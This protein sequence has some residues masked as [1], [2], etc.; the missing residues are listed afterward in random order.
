MV[1][2][3]EVKGQMEDKGVS[4]QHAAI[5]MTQKEPMRQKKGNLML[6]NCKLCTVMDALFLFLGYNLQREGRNCDL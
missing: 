3:N 4:S 5:L 2:L 6:Q 1:P